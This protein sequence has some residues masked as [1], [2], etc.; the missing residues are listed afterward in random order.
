MAPPEGAS[1]GAASSVVIA[2]LAVAVIACPAGAINGETVD[3]KP[4]PKASQLQR[5]IRL[6]DAVPPAKSFAHLTGRRG[7]VR[8]IE[9]GDQSGYAPPARRACGAAV[10]T[11][12]V[13]V[14]V[15]PRGETCSACDVR[16]FVVRYRR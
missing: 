15:H 13:F 9:H 7:Q 6:Q 5:I 12:S 3:G 1:I 10:V 16:A 4:C 11:L 2:A 14:K 8:L